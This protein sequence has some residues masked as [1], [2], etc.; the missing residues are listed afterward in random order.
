M[1]REAGFEPQLIFGDAQGEILATTID[2]E[3]A[4]VGRAYPRGTV[5]EIEALTL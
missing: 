2:G 4:E 5:V 1:L 3:P